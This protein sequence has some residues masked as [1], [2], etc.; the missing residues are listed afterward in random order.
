MGIAHASPLEGNRQLFK[1]IGGIAV[2]GYCVTRKPK[3]S[4]CGGV[5]IVGGYV[6]AR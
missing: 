3:A 4:S 5:T 2:D 1:L 6:C